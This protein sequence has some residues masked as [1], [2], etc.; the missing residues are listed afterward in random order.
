MQIQGKEVVMTHTVLFG[1]GD[2]VLPLTL[3]PD[4]WELMKRAE[5]WRKTMARRASYRGSRKAKR[6]ARLLSGGEWKR[7]KQKPP[8]TRRRILRQRLESYG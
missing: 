8:S 1:R 7:W 3:S 5:A 2:Y 6:A 4:E